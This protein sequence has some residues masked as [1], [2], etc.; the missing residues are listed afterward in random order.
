M[1]QIAQQ[2]RQYLGSEIEAQARAMAPDDLATIVYTSGTTGT[3]KGAM[4]THGNIASN[5]R[6]SLLRL[7]HAPRLDQ[8]FVSYRCATSRRVTWIFPCS[9]TA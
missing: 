8:H 7:R 3:S 5:I 6:Y 4:L 1:E 2:R 9:T